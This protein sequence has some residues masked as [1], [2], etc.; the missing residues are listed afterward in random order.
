MA[1]SA[2]TDGGAANFVF[3]TSATYP[4]DFGGA[5]VADGI[6]QAH[7]RDAGL[8]G[9]YRA[10]LGSLDG[11]PA[12]SRLG[13]ASGWVRRDGRPFVESVS[14][15]FANDTYYPLLHDEHGV[16]LPL[17]ASVWA[18]V[19]VDGGI[20]PET[21]AD[22]TRT[23]AG[24]AA[25]LDIDFGIWR[26]TGGFNCQGRAALACFGVDRPS[27]VQAVAPTPSRLIFPSSATFDF[28]LQL[29]GIAV[30]DALCQSEGPPGKSY[31]AL[32]ALDGGAPAS[33]F[34]ADAGPWVR[35]D[36]VL[37]YPTAQAFLSAGYGDLP[38]ATPWR[39]LDG[40]K[41]AGEVVN[42]GS[43]A[44][45]LPGTATCMDWTSTTGSSAVGLIG[46]TEQSWFGGFGLRL[47][48]STPR[49]VYCLEE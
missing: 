23:D 42:G 6:C 2:G 10:W 44:P 7:A 5:A 29:S 13:A 17:L 33:R 27:S 22:W 47:P 1:P 16:R 26:A 49:R 21:C 3:L 20:S 34:R 4:G 24:Y 41:P 31:R 19:D 15:L 12:P 38:L 40:G 43:P 14:A 36:G 8:C 39:Q 48:C 11:G 32:L 37:I 28:G 45:A 25:A 18:G 46:W 30:A 9:T 35:P